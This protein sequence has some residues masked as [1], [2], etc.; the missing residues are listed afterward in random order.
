M[1]ICDWSDFDKSLVNLSKKVIAGE[2]VS[3]PFPLLTLTDN[4]FLHKKCS[5][6]YFQYK[7]PFKPIFDS[8]FR[9][10]K[11][12]KIRIGYFSADLRNHPVSILTAELFE[13]H[14]KNR[15]E[16][17]AFSYG[18]DDKSP[19]RSRLNK[20]FSQFIDVREKKDREIAQLARD[21]EIDIAVDLGG[22]TAYN[23]TGIFA[24][25]AAP[26]QWVTLDI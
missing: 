10:S 11:N 23:R 20:A 13:L 25:K 15:F 19:L 17:F 9:K 14:D 3:Q 18:E 8:N 22:H 4:A 5:E 7:Y 2:K 6:I 21:L 1:K 12:K 26:I 16:I 24:H